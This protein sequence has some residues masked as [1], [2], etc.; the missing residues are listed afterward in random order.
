MD[1]SVNASALSAFGSG[2][3]V[4]AHNIANVSTRDYEA[5]SY[6]YMSGPAD[7]GVEFVPPRG[8]LYQDVMPWPEGRPY[9]SGESYMDSYGINADYIYNT[10][11][12]PRET[13][14]M[15]N[16]QRAYEA[17]AATIRTVEE[18]NGTLLNMVV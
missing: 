13:V 18:M 10:V 17:N 6:S 14:N 1:M 7:Q 15:I 4:T 8:D 5:Q 12:I 9:P 11:D 2:M 3:Q 16:T